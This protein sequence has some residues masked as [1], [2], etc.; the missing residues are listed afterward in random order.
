LHLLK[1]SW[2]SRRVLLYSR[3]RILQENLVFSHHKE[4]LKPFL[5]AGTGLM[6]QVKEDMLAY[7]LMKLEAT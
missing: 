4:N 5:V 6:H 7:W 1:E 2:G 3:E